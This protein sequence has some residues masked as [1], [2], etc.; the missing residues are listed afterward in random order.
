MSFMYIGGEGG[1]GGEGHFRCHHV[2]QATNDNLLLTFPSSSE[3]VPTAQAS[4]ASPRRSGPEQDQKCQLPNSKSKLLIVWD[5]LSPPPPNSPGEKE[6]W[7]WMCLQEEK[8]QMR[9][10]NLEGNQR[11]KR[12]TSGRTPSPLPTH[13]APGY[14][15]LSMSQC[16]QASLSRTDQGH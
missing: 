16:L 14:V 1:R 3:L 2:L 13:Q 8:E 11:P 12:K 5:K 10:V 4:S 7:A 15:H 9:P 6:Y